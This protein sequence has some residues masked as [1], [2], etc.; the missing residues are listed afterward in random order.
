M[1]YQ[2]DEMVYFRIVLRT[3]SMS[4]SLCAKT[5]PMLDVISQAHC[6]SSNLSIGQCY[7]SEHLNSR[8][9]ILRGFQTKWVYELFILA[10]NLQFDI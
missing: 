9:Y 10:C 6:T 1:I 5:Y 2:A 4:D 3:L 8:Y 7:L